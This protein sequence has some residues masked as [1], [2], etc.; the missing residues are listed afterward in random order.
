MLYNRY[1]QDTGASAHTAADKDETFVQATR[2]GYLGNDENN[3]KRYIFEVYTG[4]IHHIDTL[5]VFDL[6]NIDDNDIQASANASAEDSSSGGPTS[7]NGINIFTIPQVF[8][9]GK[10]LTG[11]NLSTLN[12]L[13]LEDSARNARTSSHVMWWVD[14]S[15]L[16]NRASDIQAFVRAFGLPEEQKQSLQHFGEDS[17][18]ISA[19]R[20]EIVCDGLANTSAYLGSAQVLSSYVQVLHLHNKPMAP[21]DPEWLL[22][23]LPLGVGKYISSRYEIDAILP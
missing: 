3:D 15:S 23:A 17:Q 22:K 5:Y 19:G 12:R 8:P 14:V 9:Q 20:G 13:I 2:Y 4:T 6:P 16:H 7:G 21:R 1:L 11:Y 18:V 10:A